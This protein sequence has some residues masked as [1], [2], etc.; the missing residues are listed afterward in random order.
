MPFVAELALAAL[1]VACLGFTAWR[2]KV[3]GY[4]P[5]PFQSNP[6]EALM[7][8]Y[9]NAYWAHRDGAY[10]IWRTVYLPVTFVLVRLWTTPSCYRISAYVARDCDPLA[11]A[12]IVACY[13]FNAVLVYLSYRNVDRRTALVRAIA[14]CVGLPMLYGLE[15]GNLIIPCFTAFVL[16]YGGLVRSRPV[17]WLFAALSINLK[18]YLLILM[19]PRLAAR[20]WRWVMGVCVAGISIYLVTYALEGVGSPI[21]IVRDLYAY[22]GGMPALYA[23]RNHLVTAVSPGLQ[24]WNFIFPPLIHIGQIGVVACFAFSVT[25]PQGV[26]VGR[27]TTLILTLVC[28]EAALHTQGY[29]ADYTLIFMIFMILGRAWEGPAGIWLVVCAY[30]LC[31]SVD[32]MFPP[33]VRNLAVS[34][35]SKRLVVT[36]YGISVGQFVRPA[37]LIAAQY[38]LVG[39]TWTDLRRA[40][41]G[42]D[43]TPAAAG[44]LGREA[45]P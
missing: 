26:D 7:D 29:S 25:R 42:P 6:S 2:F 30:L 11:L 43:G 19:L 32:H 8:F 17:R 15:L 16:A 31:M 4:L 1:V 40:P 23:A 9:N 13:V 20:R 41:K 5:H 21:D 14:V 38:I 3:L 45:R 12:P 35:W 27:F 24:A 22:A 36:Q 28:T 44:Q 37:L 33:F 34:Y 39:M 10:S 18:P